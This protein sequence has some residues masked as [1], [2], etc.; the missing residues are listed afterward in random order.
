[1][2]KFFEAKSLE[3]NQRFLNAT[4]DQF[5]AEGGKQFYADGN[6]K[7]ALSQPIIIIAENTSTANSTAVELFN[8][9]DAP[10][11]PVSVV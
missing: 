10:L 8:D 7:K 9:G 3:A 11:Y 2:K 5:Y 1:M 6:A 4:G